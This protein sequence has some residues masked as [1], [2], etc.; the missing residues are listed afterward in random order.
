M[1]KIVINY[2]YNPSDRTDTRNAI[3][4]ALM[5]ILEDAPPWFNPFDLVE[6]SK[7]VVAEV[8]VDHYHAMEG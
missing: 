6:I 8:N 1:T 2:E 3:S 4:A 7:E 5:T